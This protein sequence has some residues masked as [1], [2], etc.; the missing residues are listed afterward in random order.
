[1]AEGYMKAKYGDHYEAFSAG[2][3][4]TRVHPIAIAL[5]AFASMPMVVVSTVVGPLIEIPVMLAIVWL[6]LKRRGRII[7]QEKAPGS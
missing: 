5:T 3:E 4:A 2:M 7:Q 6:S 1:M